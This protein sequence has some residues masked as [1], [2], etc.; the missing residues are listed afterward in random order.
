MTR[1]SAT[2]WAVTFV[3]LIVASSG[4]RS[5]YTV[6]DDSDGDDDDDVLNLRPT[7]EDFEDFQRELYR[8]K[9]RTR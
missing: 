7:D 8:D 5:P 1:L 4:R 9:Q 6:D 2:L 3:T